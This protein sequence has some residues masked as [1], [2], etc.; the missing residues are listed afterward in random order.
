MPAWTKERLQ[1]V[2]VGIE[3]YQKSHTAKPA[4]SPLIT[5]SDCGPNPC[6]MISGW[7]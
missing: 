5:G 7:S 6:M 1:K 3:E 4:A 2:W